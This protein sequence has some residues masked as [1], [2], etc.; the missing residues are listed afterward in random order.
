MG[1]TIADVARE[2]KVSKTTVSRV[3]NGM[4][5]VTLENRIKV[6]RA[7]KK[8]N[9]YPSAS[10]RN[11]SRKRTNTIG[12]VLRPGRRLFV[13][14]FYSAVLSG[15]SSKLIIRRGVLSPLKRG[16]W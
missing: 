11:L 8:L 15:I 4:A 7:I 10:A 14:S 9:Y 16:K 12:F 1:V 5:S 6:E 2:A 13:N 3:L